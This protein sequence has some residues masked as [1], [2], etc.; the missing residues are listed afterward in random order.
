MKTGFSLCGKLH[1]ENPVLAL[2]WPCR[3]LQCDLKPKWLT[4]SSLS[5]SHLLQ[6]VNI[7]LEIYLQFLQI[8]HS[9]IQKSSQILDPWVQKFLFLF[10]RIHKGSKV[11]A[12]PTP[13]IL[14]DPVYQIQELLLSLWFWPLQWFYWNWDLPNLNQGQL[15]FFRLTDE[16]EILIFNSSPMQSQYLFNH[17]QS[18]DSRPV[19]MGRIKCQNFYWTSIWQCAGKL[20][21]L[22]W[23]Q[24]KNK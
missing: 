23:P 13:M 3:G 17:D 24:L 16:M 6:G 12:D 22:K 7:C 21:K 4:S 18:Q 19:E 1:R 8:K 20:N 11:L 9:R 15:R 5:Q 2:Y 14:C 10:H